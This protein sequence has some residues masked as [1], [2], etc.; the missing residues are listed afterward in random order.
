MKWMRVRTLLS[1]VVALVLVAAVA[2]C[3]SSDKKESKSGSVPSGQPGKGKPAV[4]LGDKNFTEQYILGE[5]YKQA[6]EAK[7]FTVKLKRNIGS[8]EIIDKA[9]T[10]GKIDMYPEYMEVIDTVLAGGNE[11]NR[12]TS[13]E[14]AYQK[15]KA[16]EAKR[17]FAVLDK[18]PFFNADALAVKPEY[19]QKNGLRSTADLK[20]VKSFKFGAPPEN[21]TRFEGVVGMK[22]VYGLN[23][24]KFVPLA[25]GLQYKALDQGKIDVAAVFTTDGQLQGGKLTVLTDPKGIFGYQNVAPVVNK[26]VLAKE[27]PAFAQTLNAVSSKLTVEAMRKMNGAV[28]LDQ[29]DEAKVADQFLKA[30]GLK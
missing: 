7:G 27:G 28:D 25:I 8:S 30:N 12:P 17:G 23:N 22:K 1:V 9:L 29:Q 19:A 18:T 16:F 26:K 24:L 6:L 13:A 20:K 15:A 10:S 4:T 5:L 14:D 21:K 11:K 3:G 2:A